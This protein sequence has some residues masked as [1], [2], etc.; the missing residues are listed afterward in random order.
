MARMCAA[1]SHASETKLSV[2]NTPHE[3]N[4][5]LS[6]HECN[7]SLSGI[8]PSWIGPSGIGLSGIGPPGSAL[9]MDLS[10]RDLPLQSYKRTGGGDVHEHVMKAEAKLV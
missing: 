5:S 7:S 6:G 4:S 1:P 9:R 3:C 10:L 2:A 8:G